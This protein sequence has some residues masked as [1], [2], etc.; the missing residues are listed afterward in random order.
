[1][2]IELGF[3]LMRLAAMAEKDPS[4]QQQQ[5]WKAAFEKDYAWLGDAITRHY[6]GDD[7]DREGADR[8]HAAGVRRMSVDDYSADAAS[9]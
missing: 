3:I 2:P 7:S 1:M 9:S 8:R 4:L 5:P 6:H